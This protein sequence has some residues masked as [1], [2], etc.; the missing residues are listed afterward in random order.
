MNEKNRQLTDELKKL[1]P[2]VDKLE[3]ELKERERHHLDKVGHFEVRILKL[4][5]EIL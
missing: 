2:M 3:N 5:E 4:E 1:K